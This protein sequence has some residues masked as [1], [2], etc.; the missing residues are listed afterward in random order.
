LSKN[1]SA[2]WRKNENYLFHRSNSLTLERDFQW[3][4]ILVEADL[5]NLVKI[6]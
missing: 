3:K 1:V 2:Y 5:D 6:K 4:G